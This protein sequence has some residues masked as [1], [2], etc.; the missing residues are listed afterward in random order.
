MPSHRVLQLL[1]DDF[2]SPNG[3]LQVHAT[4]MFGLQT[5]Q[6][7][8]DAC[9]ALFPDSQSES[10]RSA[11]RRSLMETSRCSDTYAIQPCGLWLAFFLAPLFGEEHVLESDKV[12]RDV[13]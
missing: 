6:D 2:S 11:A 4:R 8:A 12:E 3:A 10:T 1:G 13:Q 7:L 9:F 5:C